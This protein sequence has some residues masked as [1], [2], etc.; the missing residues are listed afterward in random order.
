MTLCA[1]PASAADAAGA[2]PQRPITIVVPFGAGGSA[3]VYARYLGEQLQKQFGQSVVVENKPGG[4]GAIAAAFVGRA[5]PDGQTLFLSSVGAISINPSLYPKLI[6][7][8][9]HDFVPVSLLV[10]VPEVLI[11]GPGSAAK[12]AKA[13]VAQAKSGDV[14]MASSGVGSMPH[15]AMV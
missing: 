14:S 4:N 1:A 5:R 9:A 3:D 13:F 12:D 10:S 7:D 2:Y 8:P 15:M 11:V 6:Y